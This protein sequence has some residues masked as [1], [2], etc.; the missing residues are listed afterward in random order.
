MRE[1]G[2]KI[3]DLGKP[4]YRFILDRAENRIEGAILFGT[5][6]DKSP[7]DDV[8]IPSFPIAVILVAA[9]KNSLI[10]KRYALA[11]AK[12]ISDLLKSEDKEKII[13]IAGT[14]NWRLRP[15]ARTTSTICD[16]TLHYTDFLKCAPVFHDKKWKLVNRQMSEGAV[17]LTVH[18]A[19]RLLE[20]EI[21]RHIEKKLEID[22]V[23]L[24]EAVMS[25]VSLLAQLFKEKRGVVPS[26]EPSGEI[27]TSAFP[28]CIANLHSEIASGRNVSHIG[29]FALT[30]FL[31]NI[32][33]TTEEV[34]NLF[35]ALPDFNE[36]LTRYQVEHIAGDRGSR[37]QYKPPRC[38]TLRTHG[39]CPSMDVICEGVRHPL[40]YYRRKL[41]NVQRK[42]PI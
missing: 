26:D 18:E 33:M 28:P 16:F 30:S 39:V 7:K 19:A 20:E 12:R 10:R 8:E 21:R 29:R 13:R 22:V 5:T 14:F 38:D 9:T 24:P 15:K 32:G 1:L 11:E 6:G 37:T 31:I 40:T 25:R 2:I 36:R 3:S 17:C 34:I 35:K 27:V 4:E 41:R 23:S 42:P